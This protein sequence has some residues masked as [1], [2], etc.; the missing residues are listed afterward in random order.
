M[1]LDIPSTTRVIMV[2]DN[3]TQDLANDLVLLNWVVVPYLGR[4]SNNPNV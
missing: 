4:G 3:E 1:P 2:D